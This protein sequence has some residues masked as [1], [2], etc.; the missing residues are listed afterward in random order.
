MSSQLE[1]DVRLLNE[2]DLFDDSWYVLNYPFVPLSNMTPAEHYLRFGARLG[3]LPCNDFDPAGYSKFNPDVHHLKMD[4]LIH[5]IRFGIAEGRSATAFTPQLTRSA[6]VAPAT[7]SLALPKAEI[8]TDTKR[9]V[10]LVSHDANIGGAPN[11]VLSLAQWFVSHTDY[12]V[13]II[14]MDGGPIVEKFE[15]VADT[16]V[17]G[18]LEIE[19]DRQEGVRRLI[20]EFLNGDPSFIIL[21]SVASGG[22]LEVNPFIS[23]ILSYIHEMPKILGYFGP[24]LKL[25]KEQ[26]TH[27]FCNGVTVRDTLELEFDFSPERLSNYPSFINVSDRTITPQADK[28]ELRKSLG[29]DPSISVVVG[30]GVVHWRKQPAL[31]VRMAID[32]LKSG[33]RANFIWVGDGEDKDEISLSID[34]LGL[35]NAIHFVGYKENFR[36]Y[37]AAADVFALTSIED[38]FPLVCLEAGLLG[39]PS[40]FFREALHNGLFL[41]PTTRSV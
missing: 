11:V 28:Y 40:V 41:I 1:L 15:A 20:S 18:S 17:L 26:A 32:L 29:L 39:V 2:S 34:K 12:K 14:C 35:S 22:Y 19:L 3:Y 37:L 6:A 8:G 23:P 21:N 16:L 36:D 31:F 38:P 9:H 10:L 5:Y 27:I 33:V 24:Q 4:P 7:T 25:I 13:S 30:C